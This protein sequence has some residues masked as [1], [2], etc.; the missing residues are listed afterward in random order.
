VKKVCFLFLLIF[1]VFSC[2]GT[3][4]NKKT[5]DE[6]GLS[7]PELTAEEEKVEA[8][9]AELDDE[10]QSESDKDMLAQD[11]MTD[12]SETGENPE[13]ETVTDDFQPDEQIEEKPLVA[14]T[15]NETK[16]TPEGKNPSV[17]EKTP[18]APPAIAAAQPPSVV[19][20]E[21]RPPVTDVPVTDQPD[22]EEQADAQSESEPQQ[23]SPPRG[24]PWLVPPPA[25][26]A[27]KDDAPVPNKQGLLPQKEDEI[28]FSR[29][30][31]AMVGQFVEIP[32]R[33]T[34]WSYLEDRASRRG[35]AYDSRRND[36]EGMIF[37]F[38]AEEAGTYALKFYRHD[39][40]RDY[41]LNDYVQVVIDEPP[42]SGGAGWFSPPIDRGRVTAE[43]RWPSAL[44]E[45]AMLRGGARPASGAA[46]QS[47][48]ENKNGSST[49]PSPA[50]SANREPSQP[51]GT[52]APPQTSS[53]NRDSVSAPG[54]TAPPSAALSN[55]ESAP[56]L[57]QGAGN[58]PPVAPPAVAPQAVM[59]SA[60]APA[61]SE[62]E[63]QAAAE[64]SAVEKQEKLPPEEIIKKAQESFSGGN[65]AEAIALLDQFMKYYPNGSDEVYW[66][67]GQFYEANTSSRNILLSLD[68]YRRLVNEYPQSR[69]FND[70]R[71]RISYLERFYINIQ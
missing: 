29:I 1:I 61:V 12:S 14:E 20:T 18:S 47:T 63:K 22:Q 44:D 34:N 8:A 30:V 49:A 71:R 5:A 69:R 40:I 48:P 45:A 57:T 38:R 16:E 46:V 43:P 54:T 37:I 15:V 19:N 33:G 50:V 39:Y 52:T 67:Y 64:T 51:Q 24:Q 4:K 65:T 32:F 42:K 58:A 66:L 25:V 35:I 11:D 55:R 59:P 23:Q 36:S 10:P 9:A 26:S 7:Q 2:K 28:V 60:V 6:P 17:E 62:P 13:A 3:P 56:A 27:V 21:E 70:A 68:N 53:A 31:H 41:I